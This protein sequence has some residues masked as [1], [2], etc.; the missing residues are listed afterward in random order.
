MLGKSGWQ[1]DQARV[2]GWTIEPLEVYAASEQSLPHDLKRQQGYRLRVSY[3]KE[4]GWSER[5]CFKAVDLLDCN[6]SSGAY[7][8]IVCNGLLG[9]PIINAPD[10]VAGIVKTLVEMLAPGGCLVAASQFHDG[11]K[12]KTPEELLRGLFEISG[13]RTEQ[14]GE[15]IAGFRI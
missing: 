9:G 5:V 1:L 3:M 8:L 10:V 2:E 15:G 13:L 11:W 12:K 7:D 6:S 14:A 4:L